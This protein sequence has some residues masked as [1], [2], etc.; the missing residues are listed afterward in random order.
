MKKKLVR[1]VVIAVLIL[2]GG[3]GGVSWYLSGLVLEFPMR[4]L[5]QDRQNRAIDSVPALGF[6]EPEV[7]SIAS[8][9]VTLKGWLFRNP[10]E[11]PCGVVASHGHGSTRYGALPYARLFFRRGCHILVFDAR[12]HG[13][14]DAP[15]GTYGYHERHDLVRVVDH[16]AAATGLERQKIGLFGS[17]M[18]AAISLQAAALIPDI[19]FVA[20]D[21]PYSSLE[22]ILRHRGQVMYGDVID[23]LLPGATW[24]AELRSDVEFDEISARAD[25]PRLTMPV[26]LLHSATDE[27]T[28]PD[29]SQRIHDAIGHDRK[30][31][32]V[33]TWGA[34]HTQSLTTDPAT[35]QALLDGFLDRHAPG[36]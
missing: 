13:E 16:F 29:H 6:P 19:A 31:L 15:F 32:H 28:P 24:L 1:I 30:E 23:V 33:T 9:G 12:R 8:D 27:Y 17:S 2:A 22:R 20:G 36:F 5:E 21:S 26:F 4:S 10:A 3:Y 11:R 7:V 34:A 18:G 25:A 35:Y 14:S